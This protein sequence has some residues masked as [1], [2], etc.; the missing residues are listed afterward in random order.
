MMTLITPRLLISMVSVDDTGVVAFRIADRLD[1]TDLGQIRLT[2]DEDNWRYHVEVHADFRQRGIATEASLCLIQNL[3]QQHLPLKSPD[4]PNKVSTGLLHRLGYK[5]GESIYMRDS[6]ERAK[7]EWSNYYKVKVR[8]LNQP[9][10]IDIEQQ[11]GPIQ[12]DACQ[13]INTGPDCFD[14]PALMHPLAHR[15]WL[16]MSEDARNDGVRLDMVSAYRS[17]AYQ[18]NLIRNKLD[19]GMCLADILRVN[20]APGYSEHH[21]GRAIDLNTPDC[22]PLTEAFADTDAFAWLKLNAKRFHYVLSYPDNDSH[23]Y[24]FEPW[25][26]CYKP[27]D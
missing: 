4:Q 9:L 26:W 20:A 17:P 16:Q 11:P 6:A 22:E 8:L 24:Q 27:F 15:I 23:G 14:R 2:T 18:A 25:H 13:L 10:G 19:R 7:L 12:Y 5:P 21:T 3:S 1:N